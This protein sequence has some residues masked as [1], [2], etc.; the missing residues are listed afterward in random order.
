MLKTKSVHSP[1]DREGDGLR[2]LAARYRGRGLP[3]TSYDVW[4]PNLGPSE[5]LLKAVISGKLAWAGFLRRYRAELFQN[6]PLDRQNPSIK[7]H[8][9]KFALR[10]IKELARRQNVTLMCHCPAHTTQC[11]RHA[12]QALILSKKI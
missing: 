8:G 5:T 11:H 9:Q 12:L 3:S 10:L 6:Q 7:N 1:I 4:M 2:I